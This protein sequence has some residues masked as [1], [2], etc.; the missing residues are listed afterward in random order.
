MMSATTSS[1]SSPS[2]SSR[3]A[4]RQ[5]GWG[6][7]VLLI[8][9]ESSAWRDA[10]ALFKYPFAVGVDGYYYILQI[11]ALQN[12][13]RFYF[14]THTPL[15]LYALTVVSYF[16][17][18]SVLAVKISSIALHLV[19]CLGIFAIIASATRSLWL[20]VLGSV[21]AVASGAHFYMIAEYVSNLGALAFLSWGGWCVIRAFQTR[22]KLWIILSLACLVAA[23]FSHRSAFAIALVIAVSAI[24]VRSLITTELSGR[25][26]RFAAAAT[27]LFLWC[28]PAI[29]ALQPFIQLPSWIDRELL[30][31]P[32]IP[33]S[34]AAVAEQIILLAI[35]PAT[36][37]LILLDKVEVQSKIARIVFGSIALWSLLVTIN[38]FLNNKGAMGFTWRLSTLAYLQVAILVPGLIWLIFPLRHEASILIAA[39]VLPLL[40]GSARYSR[41]YGMRPE[42]LAARAELLRRLPFYRQQLGQSPLV[43]SPHGEQFIVTSTLGIPSQQ[44]WPDDDRYQPIYWLLHHIAPRFLTMP[45]VV[46]EKEPEGSYTLLARDDI[47]QQ[48]LQTLTDVERK[49]LFAD[50]PHLYEYL[51]QQTKTNESNHITSRPAI[52]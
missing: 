48:Q 15:V 50:N 3:S 17:G 28:A 8:V 31:V 24:L 23:S 7:L 22:S 37:I 39:F 41:P 51:N 21:L 4:W 26:R 20:G 43:I 14:S 6:L 33:I 12:H 13:G 25:R 27:V 34:Q 9:L 46:L 29:L 36:L 5:S 16:T 10:A 32:R 38:P 18:N 35:S 45:M 52:N 42:Y 49:R 19:L 30:I 2:P 40:I 44:R 47:V 1:D 11:D